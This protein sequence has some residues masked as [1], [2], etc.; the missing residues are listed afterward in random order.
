MELIF[1]CPIT[2]SPFK[3]TDF[4]ITDNQGIKTD[5]GGNRTLDA[6][7]VLES[8]CPACG[9]M[10]IYMADELSCPFTADRMFHNQQQGQ[11]TS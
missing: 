2:G 3:S 4:K 8:P 6:K 10:H 9:Q 5:A 1:I 7:V 11:P